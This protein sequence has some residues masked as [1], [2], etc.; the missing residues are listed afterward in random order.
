MK[1]L[2]ITPTLREV[3]ISFGLVR[4]R[5]STLWPARPRLRPAHHASLFYT[6][7]SS[8]FDAV[9]LKNIKAWNHLKLLS[10]LIVLIVTRRLSAH[11]P[12]RLLYRKFMDVHVNVFINPELAVRWDSRLKITNVCVSAT[13]FIDIIKILYEAIWI[14]LLYTIKLWTVMFVKLKVSLFICI[15]TQQLNYSDAF[16]EES[17]QINNSATFFYTS[18]RTFMVNILIFSLRSDSSS[19]LKGFF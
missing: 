5:D 14:N 10:S 18:G 12:R 19:C 1:V 8:C 4:F 15:L 9:T 17:D 13:L 7:S 3:Q 11:F 6:S 16:S 2:T